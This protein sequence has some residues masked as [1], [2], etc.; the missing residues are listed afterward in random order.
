VASRNRA[1]GA[2]GDVYVGG[3]FAAGRGIHTASADA[4]K[5]QASPDWVTSLT[6]GGPAQ[7]EA[8]ARLHQ[9][10]VKM[11]LREA[12]RRS[13]VNGIV[14][15]EL[16]DLA[17]QAAGDSLLSITRKLGEFRGDSK[18]TTWAYKFVIFEV[19]NKFARHVWRREGMQLDDESW[20]QLPGRIGADP[21]DIVESQELVSEV[22]SAVDA[23]LTPHQRQIFVAIIVNGMPLDAVATELRTNRNAI[24]KT[25]FDARRKLRVH[26]AARGYLEP[27]PVRKP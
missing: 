19:S 4:S 24:Y 9:L 14:G 5:D 11:A 3:V 26:L 1:A 21:E 7:D 15:Q 10:L 13:G 25:V 18:F 20:H 17:Q 2:A 22:R 6:C 16:E 27:V 8:V 23:I 12:S